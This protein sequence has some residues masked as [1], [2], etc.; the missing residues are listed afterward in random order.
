METQVKQV[1][2]KTEMVDDGDDG[3]VVVIGNPT[4]TSFGLFRNRF[5]GWE[6]LDTYS[7]AEA[8]SSSRMKHDLESWLRAYIHR[9]GLLMT[10]HD[11]R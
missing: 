6:V 5:D 10:D 4:H 7:F 11:M 3:D 1:V 9:A 2:I 8:E